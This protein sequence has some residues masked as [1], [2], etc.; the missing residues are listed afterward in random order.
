MQ[1]KKYQMYFGFWI[2]SSEHAD[3]SALEKCDLQKQI[4][5]LSRKILL[6]K[7]YQFKKKCPA[8]TTGE[9]KTPE[10][11]EF[12]SRKNIVQFVE[13]KKIRTIV[14]ARPSQEVK[15]FFPRAISRPV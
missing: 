1:F 7:M 11:A 8:F 15:W 9:E 10:K 13:A 3:V 6:A 14:Q 4:C 12:S 5:A 2:L